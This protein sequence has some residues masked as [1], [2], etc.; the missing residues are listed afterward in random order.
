MSQELL[1]IANITLDLYNVILGIIL[2]ISTILRR[3]ISREV[4][5]WFNLMLITNIIMSAADIFTWLFEGNARPQNSIIL[6]VA[7]FIFYLMSFSIIFCSG[8][9]IINSLNKEKYK[10]I[11]KITL[12]VSAVIYYTTLVLTPFFEILYNIDEKQV[13]LYVSKLDEDGKARFIFYTSKADIYTVKVD[14]YGI[15]RYKDSTSNE[16]IIFEVV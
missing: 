16:D 12:S 9:Y 5:L 8:F 2:I 4:R 10:K 13:Y 7:M 15:G 3:V 6:P 11:I 14:Y 1:I